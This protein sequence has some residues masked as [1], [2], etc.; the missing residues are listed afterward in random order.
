MRISVKNM[1]CNLYDEWFLISRINCITLTRSLIHQT[2]GNIKIV[3]I[4]G[5]QKLF[6]NLDPVI[7]IVNFFL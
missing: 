6:I 4:S 5:R 2:L 7:L 1:V 3:Y